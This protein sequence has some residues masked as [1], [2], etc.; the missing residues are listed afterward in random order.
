MA[1]KTTLG[2]VFANNENWIGGTYY[3]L[4]LI[5]ALK[6]LPD[7][8]KP[9]LIVFL[10]KSTDKLMIEAIGYPY[11]AFKKM[12]F[13]YGL[14]SKIINKISNI[15]LQ[16]KIIKK[17]HK[18]GIVDV[19]FP[20]DLQESLG[21]ILHKIC[22]IP[23]FQEHYMK[24]FFSETVIAIR[25]E[26]QLEIIKK[27]YPLIFSSRDVAQNFSTIY[28]FAKNEVSVVNFATIHLPYQHLDI[29]LL[30]EKYAITEPYFISPNQFWKHKNHQTILD[31]VL[32]ISKK[33]IDFQIVF[34][35]KEY[36]FRYPDYAEN[37]KKFV[38]DNQLQEHIRFL[39]FID[40][41]DQLQLMNNAIATIQP[42]L[43][44]GWSTVVEDAKA[45]NQPIIASDIKVH[46]EQLETYQNKFFF[47]PDQPNNL[48]DI[49]ENIT[50]HHFSKDNFDYELNIMKFATDFM[51]VVKTSF[52]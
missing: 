19:V 42:S 46:I 13:K 41:Q 38:I 45:M 5:Y 51:E 12:D 36:D 18:K 21:N 52:S 32:A 48:A 11:L 49:L 47:H 26:H 37:L 9:M 28:P 3:I 34:T 43:F 15:L 2:L 25:R 22:W 20:Y 33:Q 35:G 16:K 7:A 14:I 27:Q 40:R 29:G 6:T 8:E 30:K 4:N 31:A 10:A 1:Q 44:E 24:T 23:D 17:R 50:T 39:G